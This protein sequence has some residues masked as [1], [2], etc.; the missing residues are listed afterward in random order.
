MAMSKAEHDKLA[1]NFRFDERRTF[2]NKYDNAYSSAESIRLLEDIKVTKLPVDFHT[3]GNFNCS[4]NTLTSLKGS[5][6]LVLRN[7]DCSNNN[8]QSLKYCPGII[9]GYF[10]CSNNF[11]KSLDYAP[12]KVS[13]TFNCTD[14]PLT[15]LEG[16]ENFDINDLY[17]PWNTNLPMLR[18]IVYDKNW[19]MFG[20]ENRQSGFVTVDE[21][22]KIVKK[23]FIAFH[24][25]NLK[26]NLK[27]SV[28]ECQRALF[29]AG[30]DGNASW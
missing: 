3:V 4:K 22:E 29:D 30:F 5:P 15:T 7:F 25:G 2:Y 26:G 14:N 1:A 17:L 21:P 13:G 23:Y 11:L 27:K 8:L 12:K 6:L 16:L 9:Q 10:D 20:G 28:L 18:L 19:Q 24:K